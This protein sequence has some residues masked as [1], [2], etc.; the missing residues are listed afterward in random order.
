ML[1][2]KPID[3]SSL[4]IVLIFILSSLQ[5]IERTNV[6]SKIYDILGFSYFLYLR[7]IM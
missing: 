3:P 6:S 5:T 1:S 2:I 7:Q 4:N